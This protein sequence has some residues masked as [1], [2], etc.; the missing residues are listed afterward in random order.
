M[1]ARYKAPSWR[2]RGDSQCA[3]FGVNV[4][5]AVYGGI[6]FHPAASPTAGSGHR[7]GPAYSGRRATRHAAVL[8]ALADLVRAFGRAA[9]A[10]E[11]LS[12]DEIGEE[13]G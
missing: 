11:W 3:D 2:E 13:E 4:G 8:L 1:T 9:H 12:L 10:L 5:H 6:H 7:T